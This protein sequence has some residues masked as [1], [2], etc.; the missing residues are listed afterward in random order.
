MPNNHFQTTINALER[1]IGRWE[2]QTQQAQAV[3]AAL[4]TR[5]PPS[6]VAP[7]RKPG[8][9]PTSK[10]NAPAKPAAAPE[11]D[12]EAARGDG[13][14][15]KSRKRRA[16]IKAAAAAPPEPPLGEWHIDEHGVKTRLHAAEP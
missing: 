3:I 8:R 2:S 15:R 10:K 14:R 9:P 6:P 12:P 5:L 16:A 4:R 13:P 7:K 11:A 1:E